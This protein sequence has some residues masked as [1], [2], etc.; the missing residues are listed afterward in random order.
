VT[1]YLALL[2]THIREKRLH[3]AASKPSREAF[4]GFAGDQGRRFFKIE[5]AEADAKPPG[6]WVSGVRALEYGTP[7][8]AFGPARWDQ[9][10]QDSLRFINQW[11]DE[12]ASL[13]WTDI[14]LFGV[15]PSAPAYRFDCMG[16]VLLI[17]GR[18]ILELNV[19]RAVLLSPRGSRLTYRRLIETGKS[20]PLWHLQNLQNGG[21]P[22]RE[23]VH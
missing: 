11:G 10:I 20:T 12:A 18:K 2:K 22:Q 16:L 7:L 23:T 3:E 4:G 9:L 6:S 15:H 13:G 17:T 14:D 21:S 8:E 5:V 19:G 1:D